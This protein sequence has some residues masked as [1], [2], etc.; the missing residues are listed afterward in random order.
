VPTGIL[1]HQHL[2]TLQGLVSR[3]PPML[4]K[5]FGDIVLLTSGLKV[6]G[7]LV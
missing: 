2:S 4:Q 7:T 6:S 3:L 1:A 5:A